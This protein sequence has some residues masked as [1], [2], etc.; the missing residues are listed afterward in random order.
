MKSLLDART[1]K[2]IVPL[3]VVCTTIQGVR[4]AWAAGNAGSSSVI[5]FYRGATRTAYIPIDVG[6]PMMEKSILHETGHAYYHSVTTCAT[7]CAENEAFAYACE[8][9]PA[10]EV[11][12]AEDLIYLGIESLDEIKELYSYQ[13][14][15]DSIR[16]DY[17]VSLMEGLLYRLGGES[18]GE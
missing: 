10:A 18:N 9:L 11:G 8:F 7:P 6:L 3:N 12:D 4:D 15:M 13:I 14:D 1:R 17:L 5:A 16:K 2:E